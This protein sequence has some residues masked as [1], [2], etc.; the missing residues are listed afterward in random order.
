MSKERN[1][2]FFSVF[3]GILFGV[4]VTLSWLSDLHEPRVEVP[5]EPSKDTSADAQYDRLIEKCRAACEPN[6]VKSCTMINDWGVWPRIECWG[7][8]DD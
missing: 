2:K 1:I 3:L 5:V 6:S 8:N 7:P 4:V